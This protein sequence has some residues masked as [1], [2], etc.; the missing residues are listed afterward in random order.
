VYGFLSNLR[1]WQFFHVDHDGQ[2][3]KSK[4][5]NSSTDHP[6]VLAAL[7]YIF[8]AAQSNTPT[9]TPAQSDFPH[10]DLPLH[11]FL[12]RPSLGDNTGKDENEYA[13]LEEVVDDVID[14]EENTIQI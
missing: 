7:R 1:R 3:R 14:M 8:R 12:K 11:P 10:H 5:F 2:L 9:T 13:L 6:E 4:E